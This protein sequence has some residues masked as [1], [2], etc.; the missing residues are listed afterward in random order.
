MALDYGE[1]RIGLALS[2]ERQVTVSE[3]SV[4]ENNGDTKAKIAEI[5]KE[6][7]VV[8]IIVGLPRNMDGS[9]GFQAKISQQ[10]GQSI[11]DVCPVEYEDETGTTELAYEAMKGLDKK[12]KDSRVDSMS[13]K[14]ILESYLAKSNN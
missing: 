12:T 8:K 13:A 3:H 2:D 4:I 9:L 7:E 6:E 1:R 5:C 10:F 11:S 14:I